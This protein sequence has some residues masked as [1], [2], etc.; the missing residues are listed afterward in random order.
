MGQDGTMPLDI[1]IISNPMETGIVVDVQSSEYPNVIILKNGERRTIPKFLEEWLAVAKH[2][3]PSKVEFG[4]HG[5]MAI[6]NYYAEMLEDDGSQVTLEKKDIE[7]DPEKLGAY[8]IEM[9]TNPDVQANERMFSHV[10]KT[11]EQLSTGKTDVLRSTGYYIFKITVGRTSFFKGGIAYDPKKRSQRIQKSLER[12]GRK[13]ISVEI[14]SSVMAPNRDI[15]LSLEKFILNYGTQIGIRYN[16]KFN[17]SGH[18]ECFSCNP[19]E[20]FDNETAEFLIKHN[21]LEEE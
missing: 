5:S 12:S 20:S 14:V 4:Q 15:A 6:G 13:N 9:L 2:C 19:M 21:I 11:L 8:L 18:T 1:P 10:L 3:L 16:P 17:F 7:K